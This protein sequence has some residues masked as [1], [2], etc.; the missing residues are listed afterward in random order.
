MKIYNL[1]FYSFVIHYYYRLLI[2]N[3]FWPVYVYTG[4]NGWT[5]IRTMGIKE[6]KQDTRIKQGVMLTAAEKDR[7]AEKKI[8]IKTKKSLQNRNSK[9]RT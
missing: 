5:D 4:C 7:K 1:L 6:V 8:K 3:A 2:Q 9:P